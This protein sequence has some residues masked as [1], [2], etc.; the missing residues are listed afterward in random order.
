MS[1][2]SDLEIVFLVAPYF[3]GLHAQVLA[4]AVVDVD[5]VVPFFEVGLG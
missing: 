2:I 5:H 4:D 1:R 3:H